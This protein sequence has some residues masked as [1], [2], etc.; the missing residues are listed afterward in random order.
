MLQLLT[1]ARVTNYLLG[2]THILKSTLQG[3][4]LR[5]QQVAKLF[6]SK[7]SEP[8]ELIF[9]IQENF[10]PDK[11]LEFAISYFRLIEC[12]HTNKKYNMTVLL[13]DII[14]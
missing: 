11:Y 5:L 1:E 3:L 9:I 7:L 13:R 14:Q 2:E 6:L 4:G 12:F 10:S 8:F